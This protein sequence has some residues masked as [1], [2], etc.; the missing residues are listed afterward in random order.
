MIEFLVDRKRTAIALLIVLILLEYLVGLIFQ[1]KTEPE[2]VMPVVYVGVGLTGISPS[3]LREILLKPI[4]E[5]IRAIEGIDKLQAFAFENYAA[6]VIQFEAAETMKKS[7]D[8][9]RDA[10]NDAKGK[11]S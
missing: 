11:I 8:K 5:E 4:E 10:I 9:V 2:I 6:A 3:R 1:L 7:L